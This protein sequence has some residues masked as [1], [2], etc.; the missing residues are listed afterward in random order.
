MSEFG[1]DYE[2]R[3]QNAETAVRALRARVEEAER[4]LRAL[5]FNT[6]TVHDLAKAKED[7]IIWLTPRAG[8]AGNK[9]EVLK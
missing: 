2:E 9:T 4:Q 7:A 3:A 1:E 6:H 8:V 5:V